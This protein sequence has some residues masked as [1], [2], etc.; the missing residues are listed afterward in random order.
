MNAADI[1]DDDVATERGQVDDVVDAGAER[2]YPFQL[3]RVAHDMI[4]HRRREAQQ[5]IG[6]GDIGSDIVVVADHIDGQ[7]WKALQQHG[8]VT[9]LHR[10]VDFGEDQNVCHAALL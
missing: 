3:W 5:H 10:F 8:P 1:G 6:V 4:R 7:L 2:L 9:A